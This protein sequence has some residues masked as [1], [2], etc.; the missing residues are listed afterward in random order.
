MD[1]VPRQY[2]FGFGATLLQVVSCYNMHGVVWV[3]VVIGFKDMVQSGLV[4]LV[5]DGGLLP[6]RRQRGT[7]AVPGGT[8]VDPQNNTHQTMI[9]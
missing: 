1:A 9:N 7:D 4:A 3:G 5:V 6:R 2:I 8:G